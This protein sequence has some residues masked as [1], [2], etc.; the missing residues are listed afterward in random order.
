MHNRQRRL[1]LRISMPLCLLLTVSC[2][3]RLQSWESPYDRPTEAVEVS[4]APTPAPEPSIEPALAL[5]HN[6]VDGETRNTVVADDGAL[7]LRQDD[8]EL[9]AMQGEY[10]SEIVPLDLPF[11]SV[12]IHWQGAMPEKT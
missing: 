12:N 5:Q 4:P 8:Q 3:A 11:N 6:F 9:Y 2:A 1:F 7:V 10:Q